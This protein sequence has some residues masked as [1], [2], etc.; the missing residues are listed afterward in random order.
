MIISILRL[1]CYL[2]MSINPI[3]LKIP[4]MPQIRSSTNLNAR[5][6]G[7]NI[8]YNNNFNT[9]HFSK[10]LLYFLIPGGGSVKNLPKFQCEIS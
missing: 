4:K 2:K 8:R 3:S 10:I 1:L 7:K 9:F 5:I 6:T